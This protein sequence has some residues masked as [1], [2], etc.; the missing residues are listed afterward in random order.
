MFVLRNQG[1]DT[2]AGPTWPVFPPNGLTPTRL[3]KATISH[4]AAGC[5]LPRAGDPLRA[6]AVT[7]SRGLARVPA[8]ST[9]VI[10]RSMARIGRMGRPRPLRLP[11]GIDKPTAGGRSR[12]AGPPSLSPQCNRETCAPSRV[13]FWRGITVFCPSDGYFRRRPLDLSDVS[14]IM[15]YKLSV[16][17]S[18]LLGFESYPPH[19]TLWR[20]DDWIPAAV[21]G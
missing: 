14:E 6:G 16:A 3:D 1:R 20:Y 18:Y 17:S 19:P 21:S 15:K 13:T 4:G 11:G 10:G 2:I 7:S 12:A 5:N 8:L 9:S